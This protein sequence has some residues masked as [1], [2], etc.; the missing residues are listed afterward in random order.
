MGVQTDEQTS[1]L[2]PEKESDLRD[3]TQQTSRSSRFTLQASLCHPGAWAVS[4]SAGL[5]GTPEDHQPWFY[6]SGTLDLGS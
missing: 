2:S 4:I 6:F 1:N 5:F 3:I